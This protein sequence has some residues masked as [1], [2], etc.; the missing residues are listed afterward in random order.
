MSSGMLSTIIPRSQL[1][2]SAVAIW[3][4]AELRSP[5][6]RHRT[7]M[8]HRA[9]PGQAR[10]RG[11]SM[12]FVI[13]APETAWPCVCLTTRGGSGAVRRQ[14]APPEAT[15]LDRSLGDGQGLRRSGL[16]QDQADSR[17]PPRCEAQAAKPGAGGPSPPQVWAWGP[18][19]KLPLGL[20][21]PPAANRR[22]AP[23]CQRLDLPAA[24]QS[25][26]LSAYRHS[27]RVCPAR[28]S[29][30]GT[31]VRLDPSGGLEPTRGCRALQSLVFL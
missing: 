12:E 9:G 27:C 10:L 24:A 26:H 1:H 11:N 7:S 22:Q 4:V 18:R 13:S 23:S 30:L 19:H 28:R 5:G 21:H 29:G 16:G 14:P 8:G 3:G 31:R 6:R 20:S 15:T 25:L 2:V 17:A